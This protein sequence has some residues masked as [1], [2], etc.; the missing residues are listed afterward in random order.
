MYFYF[1]VINIF[2]YLIFLKTFIYIFGNKYIF[3]VRIAEIINLCFNLIIN[4]T[5]VF[6][7]LDNRIFLNV[8]IINFCL[9]FVSFSSLD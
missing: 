3:P 2:L 8:I 9:F 5:L 4:L 6:Y 1:L 7:F